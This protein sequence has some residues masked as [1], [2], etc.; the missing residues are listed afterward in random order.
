MKKKKKSDAT[1]RKEM[2]PRW[3][4]KEYRTLWTRSFRYNNEPSLFRSM[5]Y[6]KPVW[7]L[8]S[9]MA[10]SWYIPWS[11][12]SSMAVDPTSIFF[13]FS[14]YNWFLPPS[15]LSRVCELSLLNSIRQRNSM[16]PYEHRWE[17]F[18]KKMESKVTT[19]KRSV[20]KQKKIKKNGKKKN[21]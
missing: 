16:V 9:S 17:Q 2:I 7:I 4:L 14:F 3:R 20:W 12:W 5:I 1:R 15:R 8:E 13:P 19:V 10:L 6:R 18:L 21:V 11:N